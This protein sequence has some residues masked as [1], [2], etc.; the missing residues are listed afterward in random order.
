MTIE[1]QRD[2]PVSPGCRTFAEFVS[3]LEDGHLATELAAALK[4][5]ASACNDHALAT[6]QPAKAG[7]NIKFDFELKGGVFEIRADFATKLPKLK[8][9][10]S[11]AWT[12]AAGHFTPSNPRQADLPFGALRHVEA[13]TETRS[14]G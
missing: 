8:R 2:V 9:D 1:T 10:R 7:L 3:M 14:V 5:I 12:N 11:V 6:M 4:E 13:K